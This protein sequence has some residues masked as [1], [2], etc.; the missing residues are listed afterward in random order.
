MSARKSNAAPIF[1]A[2]GDETRLAVVTR[3]C[4]DGPL[5]IA[6]LTDGTKVSRQAVSKHLRVL[7]GAGLVRGVRRGR[8]SLWQLEPPAV[9]E[10]RRFLDRISR[11]WD[12][13][14]ARIKT[15]VES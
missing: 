4:A 12:E 13:V 6:R 3:L 2:L 1:A 9:D 14:L 7:E 10:A 5:S 8:E 15:E 11:S